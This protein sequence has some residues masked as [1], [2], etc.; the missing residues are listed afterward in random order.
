MTLP[1]G[2]SVVFNIEMFSF[3]DI[4]QLLTTTFTAN[5]TPESKEFAY[6]VRGLASSRTSGTFNVLLTNPAQSV[7]CLFAQPKF[8]GDVLRL[9]PGGGNLTAAQARTPQS[10]SV[11]GAASAWI[12]A[13]AYGD[14]GGQKVTVSVPD[15]VSEPYGT[16]GNFSRNIV[17][18]WV[19]PPP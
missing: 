1:P 6:N 14:A 16:T 9:G 5:Q 12:Y 17:A 3:R 8:R 18:L 4:P 2:G 13:A 10:L 7:A 15:L 19:P 11:Q